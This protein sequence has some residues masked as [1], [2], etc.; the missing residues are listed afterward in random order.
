MLLVAGCSD[1]A[2]PATS[3]SS[4][5][6]T[7]TSPT[8]DAGD[9][10][11]TTGPASSTAG[12]GV[13]PAVG[14]CFEPM[15]GPLADGNQL[16]DIVPCTSAHGGEV[17]AVSQVPGASG[18]AYP[19]TQSSIKGADDLVTGCVGDLQTLGK[20]GEFVG[21]NRLTTTDR[22]D[23]GVTDAWA[24]TGLQAAVYV[25]GPARWSAGERWLV[26][27]AVLNNSVEAPAGY[28]GSARDARSRRGSLDIAFAWCKNQPDP[29]NI[30]DFESVRCDRP[31]NYEQLSTFSAGTSDAA[32]PG[33][34]ALD[35]LGTRLCGPLSSEATGGQSDRLDPALGLS[36]TFPQ[37][38]DWAR[39]ER[40]VRCFAASREGLTTGT[41]SS[42]K[43]IATS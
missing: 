19:A 27:A 24:V 22:S 41:V 39:G 8:D 34:P 37:E 25:P 21:D 31:H 42:G 11:S 13:V 14:D 43:P 16:P 9:A 2:T 28:D 32:F 5:S 7:T 29:R 18:A 10:T 36:W 30:H 23:T 1:T 15:T 20:F 33:E 12:A 38:A 26:C 4:A 17:I 35:Q 40:A 3:S 6:T